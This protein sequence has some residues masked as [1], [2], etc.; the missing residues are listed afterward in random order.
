MTNQ[1]AHKIK[2][3]KIP[4]IEIERADENLSQS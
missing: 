4:W 3:I 2:V 1:G